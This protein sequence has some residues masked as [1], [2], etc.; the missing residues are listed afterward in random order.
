MK[1]MIP[2]PGT[3]KERLLTIAVEAFRTKGYEGVNIKE[4]AEEAGMTT[5]TIYHHFGSKATLYAVVRNELEQR[6]VDRMEGAADLFTDSQGKL[7]AALLTG[8]DFAAKKGLC[9]LF[10]ETD[11]LDREDKI[12]SLLEVL[13]GNEL[14]GIDLILYAS[15]QSTLSAIDRDALDVTKGKQLVKWMFNKEL[16]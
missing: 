14:E 13:N 1:D 7:E 11:P 2:V 8:V 15:W 4:L 3:K 5:G 10:S 16:N 12:K 9:K 6:V